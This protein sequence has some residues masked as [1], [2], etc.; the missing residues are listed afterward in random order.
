[1]SSIRKDIPIEA[2]PE[3]VWAAIRDVG[4][5][6]RHLVPGLVTDV[7]MDGDDR[8][9]T[10]ANGKTIRELIVDIDDSALRLAYA[11]VGGIC[12]HHHATMQ[13]FVEGPQ[14]SRLVW[15]TD[16]LP[17][18]VAVPVGALIEQGSAIIKQTLEADHTHSA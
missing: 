17:D 5:V 16:M 15:I 6:H 13:V 7:R 18:E 1:M 12:K 11:A 8:I 9:V 2:S 4:A 14:R 3:K 10:F